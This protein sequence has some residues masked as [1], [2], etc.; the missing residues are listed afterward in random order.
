VSLFSRSASSGE[1]E[2]KKDIFAPVADLMV[3]V[4]FIFIILMLALVLNLQREDT[5][6]K[7]EYDRRVAQVHSLEA[8]VAELKARNQAL[9]QSNAKLADFVRFVRDT[10]VMRLMAQLANANQE[11]S[12]L[13]EEVRSK[14]ADATKIDVTVNPAAGTLMLPA[15]R[16]FDIGRADPTPDGRKIIVQLG[17]VLADVLPCYSIKVTQ[18]NACRGRSEASQLNA[19][20]VEGHTDITPFGAAG[21]RFSDNWDLS[22]GR[23]IEAYK[24]IS[25]QFENLRALRNRDG[26]PLLGVSGYADTRP[27]VRDAPDRRL[28]DIADKDRRIEVR[29]IMTTNEEL[30]E[31]VLSQLNDR[32]RQVEDLVRP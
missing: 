14:L 31:S 24:L 21:G 27:A 2:D 5:V 23:A 17:A 26:D 11:R 30:V 3:G 28:P 32:L 18:A 8:E 15:R 13:L 1:D 12:R 10:N 16:L 29:V 7:S 4:V 25:M 6:A 22:A 20:Y 9:S 19:V